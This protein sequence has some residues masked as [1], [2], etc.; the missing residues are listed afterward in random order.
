[1]NYKQSAATK[2]C[3]ASQDN[4]AYVELIDGMVGLLS[5]PAVAS[6]KLVCFSFQNCHESMAS[7]APMF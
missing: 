4:L 2:A 5:V 1:M 6:V 7:A 3:T